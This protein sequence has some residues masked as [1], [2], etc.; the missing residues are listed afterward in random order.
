VQNLI[1]GGAGSTSTNYNQP[2]ARGILVIEGI[3]GAGTNTGVVY[4]TPTGQKP[5]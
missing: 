1:N 4:S 2:K 5:I 3:K